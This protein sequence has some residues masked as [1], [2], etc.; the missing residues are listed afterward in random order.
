MWNDLGLI[1]KARMMELAVR[2]GIT[3]LRTIEEVYNT[4]ASGGEVHRLDDGGY[5]RPKGSSLLKHL[6]YK[7]GAD[8]SISGSGG[9]GIGDIIRAITKKNVRL[10]D[11]KYAYIF[12]TGDRYPE[13]EEPIRGFD[14]TNYLNKSGYT[15]VKDVYGI[16]NPNNEYHIDEK[17]EPLA[18]ELAKHRYHFYDNADDLFLDADPD[19]LGY[20]DDVANFIHR[21]DLD[22][23]GNVLVHDSDVY[24]FNPVD[25]NYARDTFKP[26]VSLEAKMMDKIGTPYT[27]RQEYQPLYFDGLARG[28]QNIQQHLE[29]LT[30]ADI[31][32]ITESGLLPEATAGVY[33]EGGK[34]HIKPQNRGKF[35][36]LKERTGHSASWF[37]EHGTPA[38][39]KMAVFALNARKWKHED[40]GPL[41]TFDDGGPLDALK[42]LF[43]P[44]YK[45]DTF[46]EAFS[47]ARNEGKEYF[48]WNGNR[49]NTKLNTE[50][51]RE[52]NPS[53]LM[54][55]YALQDASRRI[56]EV[57]NS[58]SNPKSGWNAQEQR[59][60]PHK[61]YEG[62]A[63]TIAYG[64][65]LSN[66][67][68]E[69]QLAK[70][71]GYLTDQQAVEAVDSLVRTYADSAEKT[72]NK[73]FGE[74]AWDELSEKSKSVLIDYEYN[75]GL[76]KF[77]NLMTGF[78]EADLDKINSEYKRYSR[79]KELG[80]NKTI[81]KDLDSLATFY[82]IKVQKK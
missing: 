72:Y 39:K 12:G 60:Y 82:P 42:K 17:Y 79:G 67:T 2:S 16:I 14:Y 33:R 52:E 70:Q 63:D 51:F 64:I 43:A 47:T 76:K 24:D 26:M 66:G 45:T 13:V 9:A 54:E 34:I 78:H 69:A 21:F 40:G 25:Y 77:P 32:R 81:K 27:I 73:K 75:P 46:G 59:W 35:T 22:E 53:N 38:Q 4:Y 11:N 62:G 80:R 49:Y 74:G 56:I 68:P 15:G 19:T 50:V 41:N 65:K 55:G 6:A 28:G 44:T 71:Q 8:Q 36:A 10:D 48:K 7:I 61:S 1:D 31:A 5:K 3:D 30:D 29:D 23:R 20:R 37:K 57:E 18:K 58:K